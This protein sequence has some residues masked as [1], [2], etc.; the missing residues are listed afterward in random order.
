MNG[1]IEYKMK[2]QKEKMEIKTE[3]EFFTLK[4]HPKN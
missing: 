1:E 2:S 4:F 3:E